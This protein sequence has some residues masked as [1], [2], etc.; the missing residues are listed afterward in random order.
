MRCTARRLAHA[1]ATCDAS[2]DG[3]C[4]AWRRGQRGAG[5]DCRWKRGRRR[6]PTRRR[7][8]QRQATAISV[9]FGPGT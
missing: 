7:Q 4:G 5:V 2:D 3:G 8:N 6:D 1:L 9:Q